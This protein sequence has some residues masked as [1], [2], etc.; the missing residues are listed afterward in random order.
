MK[1][2]MTS[3]MKAAKSIQDMDWGDAWE[4]IAKD[5]KSPQELETP[6]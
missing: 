1:A 5:A 6:P 2:R 4:M 3:E